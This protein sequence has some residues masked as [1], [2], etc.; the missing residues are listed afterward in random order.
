MDLEL[1]G[2]VALVTGASRGIG[3]ATAWRLSAEGAVVVGASRSETGTDLT[4]PEAAGELVDRVL[5]DHGRLLLE[6]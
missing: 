1:A 6:L 2:R 3:A 5:E 4:L